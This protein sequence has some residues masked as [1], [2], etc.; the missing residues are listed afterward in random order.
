MADTV[1]QPKLNVWKATWS[2]DEKQCPCD[3]HFLDYL[4]EKKLRDKAIFHMGTGNHHVIGLETARRR[5]GNHV[6]GITASKEEYDDYVQ[7]LIDNPR[8]GFT[9]KAYFG[10]IYQLDP[11]LLPPLDIA[12]LFHIGEY[13]TAEND[14]Y[15]ALTDD[16]MTLVLADRLKPGGEIHFYTGSFA[17]DRGIAASK[18]LIA[19]GL[20][21]AGKFKTLHIFRKPA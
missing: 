17:Y 16:E 13:R 1:T 3:I 2:L 14:S 5:D 8:L 19:R 18:K 21:D 10:D 20:I 7:L 11:V 12:T 6:L 9:Y 4:A 15:G